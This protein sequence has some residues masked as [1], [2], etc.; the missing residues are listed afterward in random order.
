LQYREHVRNRQDFRSDAQPRPDDPLDPA[1]EASMKRSRVMLACFM[2]CGF[3]FL[4]GVVF[5][6]S[7]QSPMLFAVLGLICFCLMAVA[8]VQEGAYRRKA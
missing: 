6:P 7:L 8:E 1:Q 4:I 2:V 3:G 5:D